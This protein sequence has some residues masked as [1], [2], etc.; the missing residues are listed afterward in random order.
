MTRSAYSCSAGLTI[1]VVNMGRDF[2]HSPT[3]V[4]DM[5]HVLGG[6][7]CELDETRDFRIHRANPQECNVCAAGNIKDLF[8]RPH[9]TAVTHNAPAYPQKLARGADT[10]CRPTVQP[11]ALPNSS[12]RDSIWPWT[13]S[14]NGHDFNLIS[15]RGINRLDDGLNGCAGGDGQHI[16]ISQMCQQKVCCHGA[17]CIQR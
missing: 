7:G 4:S 6:Q 12:Y 10:P 11:C 3:V 13:R 9:G 2:A 14:Q 16:A 8:D 5:F 15:T 17:K 1:D